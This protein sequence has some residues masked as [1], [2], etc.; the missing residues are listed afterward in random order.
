MGVNV[1]LRDAKGWTCIAV[2]AFHGH[3]QVCRELMNKKADPNIPNAY[4][5]DANDVA[6]DDEIREVLREMP[7]LPTTEY[8]QRSVILTKARSVPRPRRKARPKRKVRPKRKARPK[9]K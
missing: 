3:K 9:R 5:K 8:P 1:N 6:K 4:R 7:G 2:A